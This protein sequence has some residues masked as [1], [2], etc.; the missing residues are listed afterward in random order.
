MQGYGLLFQGLLSLQ[1]CACHTAGL[2][3][4]CACQPLRIC[5]SS[6]LWSLYKVRLESDGP[7]RAPDLP[8]GQCWLAETLLQQHAATKTPSITRCA[9][10]VTLA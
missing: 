9:T 5:I 2:L 7:V 1:A 8:L 4:G 3:A 6:E 10:F